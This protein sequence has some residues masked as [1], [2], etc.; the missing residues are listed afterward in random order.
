MSL[1]QLLEKTEQKTRLWKPELYLPVYSP[2]SV[3]M[4]VKWQDNQRWAIRDPV[5]F[6]RI[7][8]LVFVFIRIDRCGQSVWVSKCMDGEFYTLKKAVKAHIFPT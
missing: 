4:E 6:V 8:S 1:E 5:A 2:T 7:R 3:P